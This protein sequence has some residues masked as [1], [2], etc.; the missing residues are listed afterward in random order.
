MADNVD[1]DAGS[2]GATI[3]TDDDGTAHWQYVKA[4][5]GADNTQTRVTS[6]VGLPVKNL[7]NSG[8]DIGDVDVTSVV[9]GTAATNLG[10]AEDAA[11]STGDAG[12]MALSVRQNTAAST[13]GTD[14]DYQPLI[15]D[16]NG[17]LHTND[18]STA[19]ALSGSEFQVDVVAALP[20]GTNAIGKLAA[21]S[22]VDIGDVDV[23]SLNPGTGATDLGKAEDGAHT[24]GDVGVMGLSVRQDTAAATSGTDGDYQPL[25]TDANGRLHANDVSTAAALSGSEFQVDVVAALP[26]GTNAIGKLS[27]N[28]GVDIGDVDVTSVIP[29]S[30]ATNL[31]KAEDA[32][33][34]SSDVGVMALSVRQNTAASTSGTDGD[35]QPLITDTNGRLHTNDV[36]TA[37]ALSGSE[38]QVDVVAALPAGT[39][40][41]GKLSANTGVDIGDVDVLTCGTITPGTAATS[42]GKAQDT[43]VGSTDTGVAFL[44]QRDDEQAAVTP[45]DGDYVVPRCDKFGNL[46]VTQLPDAT[47]VVKFGVIDVAGSGDNTLQAAAG[48][49]IKIR[50][51]S[52]MMVSA[53][54]V[55]ARFESAA[56]GTALTG[57]M[58]LVANSGFTLPYNPAGWFET[59][60]NALLNLELSGAISV[61]GCF[62]YVEV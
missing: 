20:A 29:G 61:D 12:V 32:A 37:A 44:V 7:A 52:V 6:S 21:N 54:T 31:G 42:L 43:A 36:S 27:S 30:A 24:T 56:G 34:S 39:N 47:S 41:I 8:V 51:L 38:F 57:Q 25:I 59:A 62:T 55:T 11:H 49:G 9:P 28:S 14:G 23:T 5:F 13:S 10:K 50:V 35:Y 17:R 15:T 16:T 58:N 4:A 53:G 2:G 26:A 48:A 22:G 46:K 18:V 33:H 1:L 3:K 45:V 40:A 60:D 19:A